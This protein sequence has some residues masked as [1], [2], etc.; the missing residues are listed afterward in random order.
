MYDVGREAGVSHQTVSR[1]INDSPNVAEETQRRVREAMERLDYRPSAS[2]RSLAA[3]RTRVIGVVTFVGAFFGPMSTIQAMEAASRA[4]GYTPYT[5]SLADLELD[6]ARA[7]LDDLLQRD[8]EGLVVVAPTDEQAGLVDSVL[9]GD[10]PVL[11]L[12]ARLPGRPLVASDNELGGALAAE[13]LVSLGHTRIGHVAGPADWAEARLRTVG[14]ERVLAERGLEVVAKVDGDWSARAGHEAWPVL[15]DAGVTAVYAAND[16][17]ALG[18]LSAMCEDR[19][20]VPEDVSVVGYD[21]TPESEWYYPSLTT[22]EQDFRGVGE[23]GIQQLVRLVEDRAVE[24]ELLV[25]PHL[26]IRRSTA[27]VPPTVVPEEIS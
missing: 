18:L 23:V 8:V 21:N 11:A 13:H 5:V 26:V 20:R 1:V 9:P 16:Q 7:L 2:A 14:L 19:L 22:V 15:R 3:R 4:R 17:M 6:H 24:R 27:A 25:S 10:L 12:E